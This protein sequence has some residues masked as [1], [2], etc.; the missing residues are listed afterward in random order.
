MDTGFA[1]VTR[2]GTEPAPVRFTSLF[3]LQNS[4][5]SPIYLLSSIIDLSFHHSVLPIY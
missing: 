1:R 2:L 4:C 5:L 3:H